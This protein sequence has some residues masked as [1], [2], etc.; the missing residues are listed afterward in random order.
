MTS[1]KSKTLQT[2]T[3]F[4]PA[5]IVPDTVAVHTCYQLCFAFCLSL[6]SENV[7]PICRVNTKLR[8]VKHGVGSNSVQTTCLNL[9]DKLPNS[10]QCIAHQP[11]YTLTSVTVAP[12]LLKNTVRRKRAFSL[13]VHDIFALDAQYKLGNFT[14]THMMLQTWS[15]TIGPRPR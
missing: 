1:K 7:P 14:N 10:P 9:C 5:I 8:K 2:V 12:T 6:N 3:N 4:L 15:S 11:H 13:C